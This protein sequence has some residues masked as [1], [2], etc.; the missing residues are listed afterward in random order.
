MEKVT[1]VQLALHQICADEVNPHSMTAHIMAEH[2]VT[3]RDVMLVCDV[4][5]LAIEDVRS[6]N[7]RSMSATYSLSD[8]DGIEPQTAELVEPQEYPTRS[9][10]EQGVQPQPSTTSADM[11]AYAE[12]VNA[13]LAAFGKSPDDIAAAESARL[14]ALSDENKARVLGGSHGTA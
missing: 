9:L 8:E 13:N 12:A 2:D 14:K 11:S 7:L 10:E 1:D 4:A 3:S 6:R 5:Y